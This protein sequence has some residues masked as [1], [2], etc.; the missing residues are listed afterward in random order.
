[1]LIS[2]FNILYFYQVINILL[3]LTFQLYNLSNKSN[4]TSFSEDSYNYEPK[5]KKNRNLSYL[6]EE[7]KILRAEKKQLQNEVK[8]LKAVGLISLEHSNT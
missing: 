6:K 4:E 3:S 7:I 5:S 2:Y 8:T 1:M